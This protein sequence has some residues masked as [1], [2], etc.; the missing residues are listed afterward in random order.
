LDER[1]P[2]G[3]WIPAGGHHLCRE[4]TMARCTWNPGSKLLNL[5]TD[6]AGYP[7]SSSW[8]SVHQMES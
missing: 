5:C 2:A 6:Q 3:F 7:G 1:S 4:E 8:I